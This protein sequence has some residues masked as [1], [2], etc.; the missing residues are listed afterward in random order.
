ER[1]QIPP[2]LL[3]RDRAFVTAQ[4]ME[5]F[6]G[7]AMQELDDEALGWFSRR[8]PWGSMGMLCRASLTAPHLE[9]ALKPWCRHD[10]LLTE[11]IALSLRSDGD[12]ARI[13]IEERSV[14]EG[15]M[16]ELCLLTTL[17]NIHGY[18]CWLVDSRIPLRETT[19]PFAAP[20]HEKMYPSIFPGPVLF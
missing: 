13:C 19:F 16:R 14:P 3:S 20:A 15:P 6:A 4:Q 8:L 2:R 12:V 9:M 18:S 5:I 17:R 11:D 10:R 1:A 7:T